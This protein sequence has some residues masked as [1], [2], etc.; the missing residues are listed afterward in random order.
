MP[1][2]IALLVDKLDS[3][4]LAMLRRIIEDAIEGRPNW[5]M[6]TLLAEIESRSVE[7]AKLARLTRLPV[8]PVFA[9]R[10]PSDENDEALEIE[11]FWR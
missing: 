8:S 1:S 11:D 9:H 6:P 5:D 2:K 10:R 4:E 3:E 7:P